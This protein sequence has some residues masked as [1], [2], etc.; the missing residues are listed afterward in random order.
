MFYDVLIIFREVMGLRSLE[1][2][3]VTYIIPANAHNARFLAVHNLLEQSLFG[4][5]D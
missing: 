5:G 3:E 4:L 2:L 1:G